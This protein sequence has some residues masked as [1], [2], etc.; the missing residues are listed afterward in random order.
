MVSRDGSDNRFGEAPMNAQK[1][2]LT[3]LTARRRFF[4]VA[5]CVLPVLLAAGLFAY[6]VWSAGEEQ[7]AILDLPTAER[8]AFY[9]RTL[10]N[11]TSVCMGF[12][13]VHFGDFCREEAERVLLF[14]E[15]DDH[16]RDLAKRQLPKPAR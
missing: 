14:P 12:D 13:A 8:R 10:Q 15:C 3:T 16:C 11:L 4:F 9:D 6:W 7:R 2:L 5:G 1:N